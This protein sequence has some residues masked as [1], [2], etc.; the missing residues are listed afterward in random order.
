[1]AGLKAQKRGQRGRVS[2][3]VKKN[4]FFFEV[5]QVCLGRHMTKQSFD[6]DFILFIEHRFPVN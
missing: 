3:N 5:K 4:Y 6:R 2:A 1:M